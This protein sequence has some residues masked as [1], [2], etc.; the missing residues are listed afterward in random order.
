MR[1]TAKFLLIFLTVVYVPL[2]TLSYSEVHP[3]T[4]RIEE[5][6]NDLPEP[7]DLEIEYREIVGLVNPQYRWHIGQSPYWIR[8]HPKELYDIEKLDKKKKYNVTGVVLQENYGVIEVWVH[9]I[10]EVK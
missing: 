10:K 7:V 9:W 3:D 5:L 6:L 1:R 4:R 8:L 2:G